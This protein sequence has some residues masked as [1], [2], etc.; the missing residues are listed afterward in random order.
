MTGRSEVN[1]LKQRLDATFQRVKAVGQ[2]TELQADYSK[3]LCVLVSGFLE[4]A[5]FALVVDHARRTGAP[6]LG[7]FV[8]Q[9]TKNLANA[10]AQKLINLMGDFDPNWRIS[11]EGF[12]VDDLKGAVDSVVNLRNQI[13]HGESVP[14][15]YQTITDYYARV[16]TVIEHIAKLCD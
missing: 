3:Y 2:G 14:V 15:T 16:L 11:L 9:R 5:V 1:R 4:K 8:H 10:N 12:L 13:A 6:P 7:R